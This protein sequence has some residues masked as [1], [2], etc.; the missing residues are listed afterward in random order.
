MFEIYPVPRHASRS[1]GVEGSV[2]YEYRMTENSASG[3]NPFRVFVKHHLLSAAA[4]FILSIS[5]CTVFLFYEANRLKSLRQYNALTEMLAIK[6]RLEGLMNSH[7]MMISGLHT[8]LMLEPDMGSSKFEML[9]KGLLGHST[10][11]KGL[12][13]VPAT[14][15]TF[16]LNAAAK[17]SFGD[18]AFDLEVFD[19]AVMRAIDSRTLVMAGPDLDQ[20]KH[21][22]YMLLPVFQA[23]TLLGV[24][25]GVVDN[26]E[27]L[28][29]AGVDSPNLPEN[30]ALR[31]LAEDGSPAQ[32]FYGDATAFSR[33]SVQLN[34]ELPNARWL[35]AVDV[36]N[37]KWA[38]SGFRLAMAAAF[39]I[40]VS[41]LLSLAAYAVSRSY[42]RREQAVQSANYRANYDALTG[43]INRN[44][45]SNQLLQAI[46]NHSRLQRKFSLMFID[47][48]FFK[49]VNDTWGHRAGDELLQEL[50]SRLMGFVRKSDVVARLAGDEFVVLMNNAESATQVDLLANRIL[51]YLNQPYDIAGQ[52]LSVSCSIGI[53]VFPDDGQT[54]ESILSHSDTAMYAAKKAGRN[55]VTFFNDAM[56]DEAQFQ[57]LMHNEILNG[58]AQ[59]E[60]DVFYQ[61][62][63]K[64][65]NG[66]VTK[67]EALI[68]WR[69]PEK[70]FIPPDEFI[71][72]AENTGAIRAI[73]RWVLERVCQDYKQWNFVAQK[74]SV[75]INRS[76][77]EFYPSGSH[78]EWEELVSS[79]G[80]DPAR[81]IFEITE[82]LFM[83]GNESP[84]DELKEMRSNGFRFAIDDFGT[85]YSAIN[86]LRNYPVNFIKIDRSFVM[87]ILD[88]AQDRTLVE[89]IIKMGKA[90]G[91]G[92]IAEGVENIEQLEALKVFDCDYIQGYYLAKPMPIADFIQFCKNYRQSDRELAKADDTNILE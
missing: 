84:V 10:Q 43:L 79:Y 49:Q 31:W 65:V 27:M 67:C 20:D 38:S 46:N 18:P 92:V 53:A 74:L 80:I 14:K 2:N 40:F 28:S 45:F 64:M 47:L 58:L 4:V 81:I 85:G 21:Y 44:F 86:Y 88:N 30:V 23:D 34:I 39:G 16:N 91:I 33:S 60:F 63:M 77:S 3:N 59:G 71:G 12:S 52:K 42:A 55:R 25:I 90:L 57:L 13:W 22:L 69:H 82:S 15:N 48:D 62:I 89:V 54:A 68:R 17:H 51:A 72:I 9:A 75:S 29:R 6:A 24:V 56:R 73:G 11:M 70:G 35:A 78:R 41:V 26:G 1:P 36:D 5:L 7:S 50:A 37:D 8:N 61:P 19:S 87:D 32:V 83:D 76:V 66:Q